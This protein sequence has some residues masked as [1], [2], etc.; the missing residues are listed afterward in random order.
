M[1]LGH[2]VPFIFTAYLQKALSAVVVIQMSDDE[3]Y[4]FKGSSEGKSIEH[5]N[6]L[7][8]QNTK[9]IIACNFIPEKTFIFSNYRT[10]GGSLYSNVTR[11]NQC[12]T[13]NQIR[14]IYGLNLETI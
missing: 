2:L 12:T 11:I 7:T 1:H 13:G 9:D 10:L 8:Y 14:G 6:K 4:Y 3:K 5:Y